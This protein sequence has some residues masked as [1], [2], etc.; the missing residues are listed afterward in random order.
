M[1]ESDRWET[2]SLKPQGEQTKG[3]DRISKDFFQDSTSNIITMSSLSQSLIYT[4][5][6]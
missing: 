5:V 6:H 3:R 1:M 2:R 4:Q